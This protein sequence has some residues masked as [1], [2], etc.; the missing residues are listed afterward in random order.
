MR[1]LWKWLV[2]E[3]ATINARFAV[4]V[5]VRVVVLLVLFN[6]L[7]ILVQPIETGYPTLYNWIYPGRTRFLL[8]HPAS[9]D[10]FVTE[11]KLPRLLADHVIA[12]PRQANEY[13]VAVLGS[14]ETWGDRLTSDK[15]ITSVLNGM[16]LKTP[17]GRPVRFY[18]LAI[19]D[20]YGLKDL[21]IEDYIFG[22][23]RYKPDMLIWMVNQD[24][25]QRTD[26]AHEYV[27]F[28]P[29]QAWD[30]AARYPQLP[31]DPPQTL[32]P[33]WLEHN[34]WTD[35]SDISAWLTN[36][37][38]GFEYAV[39]GSDA[40]LNPNRSYPPLQPSVVDNWHMG[41]SVTL[42]AALDDATRHHVPLLMVSSP[43][44]Y[45]V[46][47]YEAWLPQQAVAYHFP[48]LMCNRL[49]PPQEFLN[50]RIHMSENGNRQLG[51]RIAP[52]LDDFWAGK[53]QDRPVTSCP[54]AF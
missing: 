35:R 30:L 37:A 13:R 16:S 19:I 2:E 33:V 41:Q 11:T 15:T 40:R 24:T 48:L 52:W 1:R 18:N 34:L 6:G 49:L 39:T 3:Q 5:A 45:I 27:V 4:Q 29:D 26:Y 25:L 10:I 23:P 54:A 12:Q 8:A 20:P 47:G 14:S 53:L 9:N 46:P 51:G 28:N 7:Y 38:M 43:I 42:E 44:L 50:T 31:I 22:Q 21:L 32:P 36:Q 17:D